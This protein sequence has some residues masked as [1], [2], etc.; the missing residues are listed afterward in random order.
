M[1]PYKKEAGIPSSPCQNCPDRKL[2]CHKDCEDYQLFSKEL[3]EYKDKV[4]RER[5]K[6]YSGNAS[7]LAYSQEKRRYY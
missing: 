3:E 1:K 2:K 7:P 6:C 5:K 4:K